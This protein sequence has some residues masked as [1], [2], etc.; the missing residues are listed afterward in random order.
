MM[1]KYL[2]SKYQKIIVSSLQPWWNHYQYKDKYMRNIM[3]CYQSE[4]SEISSEKTSKNYLELGHKLRLSS[5][6]T[7]QSSIK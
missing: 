4:T 2:I 1:I 5:F 3:G 7:Y 6:L